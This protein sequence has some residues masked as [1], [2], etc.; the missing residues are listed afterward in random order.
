MPLPHKTISEHT[1]HHILSSLNIMSS[2][3][4]W[5]Y[6]EHR[7]LSWIIGETSVLFFQKSSEESNPLIQTSIHR[8]DINTYC[9][10]HCSFV[11]QGKAET[12]VL[13]SS[14]LVS[15]FNH[16]QT[17]VDWVVSMCILCGVRS[18]FFRWFIHWL[19]FI[20]PLFLTLHD[21]FHDLTTQVIKWNCGMIMMTEFHC[22]AVPVN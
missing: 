4:R 15:V 16:P 12:L 9:R 8:N 5:C 1:G 18:T 3:V 20:I 14:P 2:G 13:S 17:H 21:Y 19:Q 22:M 6:L 7:D 10:I 11:Q